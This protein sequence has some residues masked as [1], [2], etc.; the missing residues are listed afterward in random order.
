LE[1]VLYLGL[2]RLGE[3]PTRSGSGDLVEVQGEF[4]AA[5]RVLM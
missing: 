4:F 2:K 3:H 5:L 1:V